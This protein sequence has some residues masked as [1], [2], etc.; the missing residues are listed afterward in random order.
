M[1]IRPEPA[2]SSRSP[3]PVFAR[4]VCLFAILAVGTAATVDAQVRTTRTEQD[5]GTDVLLQAVSPVSDQIV[6]ASGH[7]GTFART[8]DGGDTWT[9]SVV[10]GEE[11]LQFRDIDAFSANTAYMM[12]A[13]GGT[14][15]RIYRTDDGGETWDLQ[16]QNQHPDGF[17]DCM[18]FW[19]VDHGVLY[20]DEIDGQFYILRTEDGGRS[21]NRVPASALPPA[22]EGEGGFAASGTCVTTGADGR[23]WISTGAAERARVLMTD[24]QGRTWTDVPV[25]VSGGNGAGLTT[26]GFL[27]NLVG[28]ALGGVIGDNQG[29]TENVTVTSDG[30]RT[31]T[32]GG[33]S[34]LTGPVYGSSW[35]PGAPQPTVFAVGPGGAD[36][37]VDGGFSWRAADT[38]TYWAVSFVSADRGWAVG[39]AGRITRFG[40]RGG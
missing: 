6:W 1:I 37:S 26:I 18:S 35:V 21:W 3:L 29:R 31:W 2:V 34:R 8:T 17:F 13:G 23:G 14:V 39:P 27:D 4:A 12:S 5:S 32:L 11:T 40:F 38:R 20:G 25:P 10:P 30:G 15:S 33:R 22:Q 9:T 19:D 24:D 28:V 7:G 16:F 36:F